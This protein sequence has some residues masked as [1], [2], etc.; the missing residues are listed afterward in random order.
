MYLIT[1]AHLNPKTFTVHFSSTAGIFQGQVAHLGSEPKS[2][3]VRGYLLAILNGFRAIENV[4]GKGRAEL[5]EILVPDEKIAQ[6]IRDLG[7]ASIS[8]T[9]ASDN[10]DLWQAVLA[11]KSDYTVQVISHPDESDAISKLWQWQLPL[12]A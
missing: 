8:K 2:T 4:V 10:S 9:L 1:S 3:V 5:V 7:P 12:T 6:Q 11:R